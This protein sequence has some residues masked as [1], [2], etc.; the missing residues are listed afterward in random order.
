MH[1]YAGPRTIPRQPVWREFT[2]LTPPNSGSIRVSKKP[3]ASSGVGLAADDAGLGEW[4]LPTAS[5]LSDLRRRD[6]APNGT[7]RAPRGIRLSL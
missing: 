1:G 7:G 4:N 6:G 2:E 3:R 5:R